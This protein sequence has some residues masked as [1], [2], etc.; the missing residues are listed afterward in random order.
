MD[1][2]EFTK[3]LDDFNITYYEQTKDYI[4]FKFN[5]VTFWVM[6]FNNNRLCISNDNEWNAFD[7][8]ENHSDLAEHIL[9]FA[10][11]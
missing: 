10:F 7:I 1:K 4:K 2:I 6:D 3:V 8:I 9:Q 11:N 5:N